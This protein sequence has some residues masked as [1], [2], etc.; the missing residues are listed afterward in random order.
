MDVPAFEAA[1]KIRFRL[2]HPFLYFPDNALLALFPEVRSTVRYFLSYEELHE[3]Q[4]RRNW[5][6]F[7]RAAYPELSSL[8]LEDMLVSLV[9]RCYMIRKEIKAASSQRLHECVEFCAGQ[10]HLTH[11]C[12]LAR[13]NVLS[14]LWYSL[15]RSCSIV[16]CCCVWLG[17]ALLPQM[18]RSVVSNGAIVLTLFEN[19]SF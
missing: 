13:C 3:G 14:N 16:I 1:T 4:A 9:V 15:T 6:K 11:A 19:L 10:G 8:S 7:I 5:P 12:N 2:H 18:W 17:V